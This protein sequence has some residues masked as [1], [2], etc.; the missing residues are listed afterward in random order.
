MSLNDCKID[1]QCHFTSFSSLRLH[2]RR[3]IFGLNSI[4]DGLIAL[5]KRFIKSF[6][7][8]IMGLERRNKEME[9]SIN[10]LH[11]VISKERACLK[12]IPCISSPLMRGISLS[13]LRLWVVA[14]IFCARS[15]CQ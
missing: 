9:V 7:G 8:V 15:L 14:G 10:E 6:N 4:M 5:M 13:A 11:L 1:F 12:V 3:I 2:F